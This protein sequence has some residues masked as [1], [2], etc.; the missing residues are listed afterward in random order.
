MGP[1][2]ARGT[3][4]IQ[5]THDTGY[6]VENVTTSSV[7]GGLVM[8]VMLYS[9]TIVVGCITREERRKGQYRVTTASRCLKNDLCEVI[10]MQ[11]EKCKAEV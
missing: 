2:T 1:G 9:K 6:V 5:K 10:S 8:T 3:G 4:I 7:T 11:R